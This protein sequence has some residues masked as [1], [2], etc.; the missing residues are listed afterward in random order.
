MLFINISAIY[1][2]NSI[3]NHRLKTLSNIST[4]SEID[5]AAYSTNF[6]FDEILQFPVWSIAQAETGEIILATRKGIFIFD[7]Q[8]SQLVDIGTIPYI[9]VKE[10]ESKTIFLGCNNGFGYL[11]RDSKGNYK[12][13]AMYKSGE[14]GNVFSKIEIAD[15]KVWFYNEE[16]ILC[17]SLENLS[18]LKEI[19]LPSS[20]PMKGIFVLSEKIYAVDPTLGIIDVSDMKVIVIPNTSELSKT[21]V[22]FGIAWAANNSVI[23]GTNDNKFYQFDG[24][25]LNPYIIE[26]SD[27][28]RESVVAG[29]TE[30]DENRFVIYTLEGGAVLVRKSDGQTLATLNYRTGLPEDEIYATAL[31]K[32]NGLWLSHA[33]G[34]TRI[35]F[36]LP[37][38]NYSIFPG[39]EGSIASIYKSDTSLYI[40]ASDG[41]FYLTKLKDFK[42]IEILEKKQI[43]TFP[44]KKEEQSKTDDNKPEQNNIN[45]TEPEEKLSL[46]ER[47]KKWKNR[48]KSDENI[49]D[50]NTKNENKSNPNSSDLTNTNTGNTTKKEIPKIKTVVVSKKIYE[51]Q[52]VK[53]IFKKIEGVKGK[54]KQIIDFGGGLLA[55]TNSGLYFIKGEKVSELIVKQYIND[56]YYENGSE[57]AFV[58]AGNKIYRIVSA[59]PNVTIEELNCEGGVLDNISS[60]AQYENS[61]WAGSRNSVFRLTEDKSNHF[62]IHKYLITTQLPEKI[63]VRRNNNSILFFSSDKIFQYNKHSD[64]IVE[65]HQFDKYL[66][67]KSVFFYPQQGINMIINGKDF[68]FLSKK[69]DTKAKL[70]FLKL[71]ERLNLY[72]QDSQQ[73]IWF[74]NEKNQL[75]QIQNSATDSSTN[76]NFNV[77]IQNIVLNES[78]TLSNLSE[79]KMN[80]DFGNLHVQVSAPFYL[81]Q[82]SVEYYYQIIE[83][84]D[85]TF[86]PSLGSKIIFSHLAPGRFSIQ[87]KAQNILGQTSKPVNLKLKIKPPFSQSWWFITLI[88][89]G[90]LILGLGITNYL[91]RRREIMMQKRNEELEEVVLRRTTEIRKQNHEIRTKND[92]I[93]VQSEKIER[94]NQEIQAGVRYAS[95]IQ[96]AI[97]PY[98]DEIENLFTGYF[99]FYEPRDIVSG[100]FYWLKTIGN[101]VFLVAADC[102]G[103]GVPGGFLSMLGISFL[104]EIVSEINITQNQ[105]TAGQILDKLREKVITSLHQTADSKTKDGMDIALVII[106]RDSMEMEF[107]GAYNPLFIYREDQIFELKADRM[108]IA[109]FRLQKNFQTQYFQLQKNDSLYLFSDGLLDQFGGPDNQ[110]FMRTRFKQLLSYVHNLPPDEQKNM[111]EE[112]FHRWQADNARVDD[113]LLFNLTI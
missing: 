84:N 69:E 17:A 112:I 56:I 39:I 54:V 31:D 99:I 11:K 52:S 38:K 105:L 12:Y 101:K 15:K 13:V 57:Q 74:T 92:A 85:T 78:D 61:I 68:I 91:H 59:A 37:V 76:Q 98:T 64:S 47:W 108:P 77:H 24:K 5:G 75:Y 10:P 97:L 86:V 55:E 90:T 71:F 67:T 110:R 87:I 14:T 111:I 79:I 72:Y 6:V 102:T 50:E 49:P 62:E 2:T 22:L 19:V 42:E 48:K 96:K 1:Y 103:H 33:S 29:G 28:V 83:K 58:S 53:N 9:V 63:T 4:Y 43:K 106:D 20:L 16:K 27:Y 82:N 32:E 21:N 7:G 104:N 40:G 65:N 8:H 70:K 100:D 45:Q 44:K 46:K 36:D 109:F 73:N 107:A 18:K 25:N 95:L 88:V 23:I 81:K 94:Q 113:V 30:L 35:D 41:L 89:L 60:I 3:L 51:L 93:L 80:H 66:T 34:L 26:S